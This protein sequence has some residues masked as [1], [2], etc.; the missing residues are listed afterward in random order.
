MSN[1]EIAT[2]KYSFSRFLPEKLQEP[3]LKIGSI[4][5]NNKFEGRI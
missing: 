1:F 2:L 3:I 5:L 4:G